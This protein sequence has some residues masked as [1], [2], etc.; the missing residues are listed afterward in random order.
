M[1]PSVKRAAFLTA[2][3]LQEEEFLT[4][5]ID[6]MSVVGF[7]N[8]AVSALLNF[9]E[10]AM[11]QLETAFYRNGQKQ[12]AMI[13]IV[14]IYGL[15]GGERAIDLLLRKTGVPDK[16]IVKE[17]LYSLNYCN[18]TATGAM[19]SFIKNYLEQSVG[20]TLWLL[21]TVQEIRR[22]KRHRDVHR[23]LQEL[24]EHSYEEI[25]LLLSLIY[26]KRSVQLIEDNIKG[27]TA[28]SIGYAMELLNIVVEDE[29]K[30]I[31]FPILD[32][33]STDDKLRRLEGQ[34]P[35]DSFDTVTALQKLMNRDYNSV[36]RWT[37]TCATHAYGRH[38]KTK[39]TDD[40]IANIFNPDE[41][42]RETAGWAICLQ[43]LSQYKS[44]CERLPQNE[45]QD[46]NRVVLPAVSHD[47]EGTLLS[48][49][50]VLYLLKV[51]VLEE[52]PG[53]V[54]ADL[55]EWMEEVT[56]P[57][58]TSIELKNELGYQRLLLVVEGRLA[59][60]NAQGEAGLYFE[61]Y[62]MVSDILNPEVNPVAVERLTAQTDSKAYL[63][64]SERFYEIMGDNYALTDRLIANLQYSRVMSDYQNIEA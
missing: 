34:F 61:A 62:D 57:S 18:W 12:N 19:T 13:N 39:V 17:V 16:K 43:S 37:R 15:L 51:P 33:S 47:D 35:R 24:I 53:M 56:I 8:T 1:K 64:L 42:V 30:P 5:L 14:Q 59:K 40:L 58:G 21:V 55:I 29:M 31:L 23:A 50:K 38:P 6:H 54:L 60:L 20:N 28:D 36:D 10:K 22:N 48:M 41:L 2:G 7:E 4:V 9:G 27:G 63:I 44:Y 3:K 26:D 11:S 45:V 49:A 25:F 32:D 52:V 46:M